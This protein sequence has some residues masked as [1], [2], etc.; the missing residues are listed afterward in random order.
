M[1]RRILYNTSRKP[2][3]QPTIAYASEMVLQKKEMGGLVRAS[4]EEGRFK[5]L[6]VV[7]L[8]ANHTRYS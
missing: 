6:L 7:L 4:H 8:S 5:N 2:T 3:T 1:G